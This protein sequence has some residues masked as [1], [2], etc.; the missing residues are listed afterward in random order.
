MKIH[1]VAFPH[2]RIDTE[3]VCGFSA[4]AARFRDM[5]TARGH[6]VSVYDGEDTPEADEWNPAQRMWKEYNASLVQRLRYEDGI[7][8]L[9]T[10][11]PHGELVAAL[12]GRTFVEYAIGYR[13]VLPEGTHHVFESYAWQH[14][15]N[16]RMDRVTGRRDDTVICNFYDSKDFP[17]GEDD[18]YLLFV[19]RG[20]APSKGTAAALELANRSKLELVAVG[21]GSWPLGV[22]HRGFVSVAERNKLMANARAVL[23]LTEFF[24]PGCSVAHEAL[25]CGTPVISSDWGCFP[26]CV[27]NGRMGWRCSSMAEMVT[28]VEHARAMNRRALRQHAQAQW[29]YTAV[30]PQFERYFER[31]SV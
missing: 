11:H 28:A 9:A 14:W 16:G 3:Q 23:C 6:E 8:C 17:L 19:G 20:D 29:S 1:L 7:I 31:L 22:D 27:E 10:G 4:K 24:E 18:G 2:R 30:A 5:M 25:M 15:V 26:E 21:S 13:G 12:P